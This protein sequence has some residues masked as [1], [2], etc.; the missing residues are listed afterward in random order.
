MII[1]IERHQT[2]IHHRLPSGCLRCTVFNPMSVA[3]ARLLGVHAKA[4]LLVLGEAA[5][6]AEAGLLVLGKARLLGSLGHLRLLY[7]LLIAGHLHAA[8][9]GSSAALRVGT[10]A[11]VLS[12]WS[13]KRS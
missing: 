6:P 11:I 7:I 9:L 13:L 5:L 10:L 8:L 1:E 3:E 12:H 4:G 2:L